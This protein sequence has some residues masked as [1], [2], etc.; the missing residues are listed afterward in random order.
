MIQ[1]QSVTVY[2]DPRGKGR[3]R[4]SYGTGHA[5]T[6][7]ATADYERRVEK[8][9]VSENNFTFGKYPTEVIIKAFFS[10]PSSLSKK[11]K[12]QLYGMPCL[13]KPDVDNI[14]K[15]VLDAL[16]GVAYQDDA[17]IEKLRVEKMYVSSETE[18]PRVEIAI[19]AVTD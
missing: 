3:P 10:V 6:D 4:F 13:K 7:A 9:W 12:A 16:N 8:A 1:T 19:T 15:I 17:Q 5:Y 14:A 18:S 11:K 2:G